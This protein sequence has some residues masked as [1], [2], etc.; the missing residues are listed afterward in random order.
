M[1][2][3][4]KC[5]RLHQRTVIDNSCVYCKVDTT[6]LNLEI[7]ADY[8]QGVYLQLPL[9]NKCL[10]DL[11]AHNMIEQKPMPSFHGLVNIILGAHQSVEVFP[12]MFRSHDGIASAT[13][14]D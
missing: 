11:L 9:L 12:D 4:R 1:I 14:S 2:Q 8:S 7:L 6:Y 5:G 10:N 13:D 3:Q